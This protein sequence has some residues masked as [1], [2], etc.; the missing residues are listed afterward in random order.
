[1][2]NLL[3]RIAVL[4]QKDAVFDDRIEIHKHIVA[5]QIVDLQLRNRIMFAQAVEGC[6]LIAGIVIDMHAGI[7]FPALID[8]AYKVDKGLLFLGAVMGPKVSKTALLSLV[9][10]G[11]AP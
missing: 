8:P 2:L 1:M 7:S 9:E 6:D 4:T 5:Q 11:A 10:I 3:D